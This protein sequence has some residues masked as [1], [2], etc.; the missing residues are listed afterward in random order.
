MSIIIHF[1]YSLLLFAAFLIYG[2][3]YIKRM[4]KGSHYRPD[5]WKRFGFVMPK[6]RPKKGF[7]ILI[8]AVSVGE[9]RAVIPV[10]KELKARIR[11]LEI[12]LTTTTGTGQKTAEQIG[13]ELDR[14]LYFPIDFGF[15]N[16]AFLRRIRP[17][18]ICLTETEIW[19]NFVQVAS[20]FK[21]PLVLI[22]G[23]ISDKSYRNYRLV[24]PFF[25]HL[26]RKFHALCMQSDLDAVR[27]L[28]LGAEREK[29]RV[30]G[31]MKFDLGHLSLESSKVSALRKKL[32]IMEGQPVLVAGSTHPG[33]E[34]L[35]IRAYKTLQATYPDHVLIVAP[36]H[37]ERSESISNIIQEAGM[38]VILWSGFPEK[39]KIGRGD[40]LLIDVIGILVRIYSLATIVVMGGSFIPHGGQNPLEPAFF[41]KPILFGPHMENF[42]AISTLLMDAGGAMMIS[43]GDLLKTLS[44][45]LADKEGREKMGMAARGVLA[46][47]QG[48]ADRT[49]NEIIR[50]LNGD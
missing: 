31:N 18:C 21:I 30:T 50:V 42:R 13:K 23:R 27:I 17:D 12:Y 2:P 3:F 7:R 6:P 34:D 20:K 48:S 24:R 26:L 4:K 33:E 36:R 25:R 15:I 43:E 22:N 1:V 44:G 32:G 9:T 14:V 38:K 41:G 40:V 46:A 35:I 16:A 19:P 10:V 45:L 8:H 39:G 37:I 49:C 28:S 5:L 47:N 11:D 29:V